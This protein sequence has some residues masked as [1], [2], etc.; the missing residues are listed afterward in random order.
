MA[1]LCLSLTV[2]LFTKHAFLA[3]S[4]Y[5][6]NGCQAIVP[7][8]CIVLGK[9]ELRVDSMCSV[10]TGSEGFF[11]LKVLRETSGADPVK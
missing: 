1:S 7:M 3:G 10:K 6:K 11:Q 2:S 8:R 9:K 4:R 5:K